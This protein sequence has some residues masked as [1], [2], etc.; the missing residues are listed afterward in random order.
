MAIVTRDQIW[1][2]YVNHASRACAYSRTRQSTR[3][4]PNSSK[5]W[6]WS[7]Y[8]N[9]ASRTCAYSSHQVSSRSLHSKRF[10]RFVV[11]KISVSPSNSS[12]CQ[13][14]WLGF[15]IRALRHEFLINIKLF[16]KIRS[17]VLKLKIL[18]FFLIFPN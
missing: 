10:Q 14:N 15:K 4:P 1:S 16:I 3:N 6:I 11:S 9:N 7:R 18:R 12:Q 5:D 13:Q 8:V 17:P 2:F